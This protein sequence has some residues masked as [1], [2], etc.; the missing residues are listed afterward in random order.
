VLVCLKQGQDEVDRNAVVTEY[1][2]AVLVPTAVVDTF[3]SR[4]KGLDER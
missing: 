3:N 4:I 1:T 2:D